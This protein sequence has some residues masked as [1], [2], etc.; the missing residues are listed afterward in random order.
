M[1]IVFEKNWEVYPNFNPGP[2]TGP[3]DY[4]HNGIIWFWIFDKF[5]NFSNSPWEIIGSCDGSNSNMAGVN[6]IDHPRKIIRSSSGNHSWVVLKNPALGSDF[7]VCFDFNS[8]TSGQISIFFSRS[9]FV[10][11][12]LSARPTSPNEIQ[13]LDKS[14]LFTNSNYFSTEFSYGRYSRGFLHIVRSDD[15]ECTRL[16]FN[17][18][19]GI[20][21]FLAF[22]KSKNQY[23]FYNNVMVFGGA[24][25]FSK[26]SVFSRSK[27]ST[28]GFVG[29]ADLNAGTNNQKLFFGASQNL[30]GTRDS[31]FHSDYHDSWIGMPAY[32]H[33]NETGHR[34]IV[35]KLYDM[36]LCGDV[37]GSSNTRSEQRTGYIM[38]DSSNGNRV[39]W[40][41][42][43][44]F[45]WPTSENMRH[46]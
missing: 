25:F 2:K 17:S 21:S 45:P 40:I 12:T 46:L 42:G 14:Y 26:D 4:D 7:M 27:S 34:G 20:E 22:E 6:L 28:I 8:S 18:S 29:A 23:S 1:A 19:T 30:R 31:W 5:L 32:A 13:L 39:L 24:T 9:P 35:G 43:A 11:G 41:G 38:E 16:I 3:A 36:W 37:Y 33:V 15:G 10:G 44:F